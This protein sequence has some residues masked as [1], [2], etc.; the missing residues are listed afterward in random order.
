M[1]LRDRCVYNILMP[2]KSRK[3]KVRAHSRLQSEIL[4]KVTI[5]YPAAPATVASQKPAQ[6]TEKTGP[7]APTEQD[8]R[9]VAYFKHDMGRSLM[10]IAG[11]IALEIIFYFA[12]MSTVWSKL[13]N[14]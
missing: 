8:T 9:L 4:N 13:F 6:K 10:L 1:Q 5:T 3:E 7:K 14:F 11:I 12:S 2:K